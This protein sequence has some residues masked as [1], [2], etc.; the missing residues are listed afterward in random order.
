MDCSAP[1]PRSRFSPD[2]GLTA[3]GQGRF[4]QGPGTAPSTP[5]GSPIGFRAIRPGDPRDTR[6]KSE[7][8]GVGVK[9]QAGSYRRQEPDSSSNTPRGP[10]I[11]VLLAGR[12]TGQLMG[13]PGAD[14]DHLWI[15]R[16]VLEYRLLWI[17][18]YTHA[19]QRLL[20]LLIG[21]G[22]GAVWM[23]SGAWYAGWF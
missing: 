22:V 15:A 20:S 7:L 6:G 5:S 23:P 18:R 14:N 3:P 19:L 17:R 4:R 1:G 12:D 21:K 9:I 11:A 13:T 8:G 10:T 2:P 16:R